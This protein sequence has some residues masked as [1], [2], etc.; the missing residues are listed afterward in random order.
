MKTSMFQK[1]D[2]GRQMTEAWS[3]RSGVCNPGAVIGDRK[4]GKISHNSLMFTLIE[5]LVVIAIIAI[6]AAMLLPALGK[7]KDMAKATSCMNNLKQL[8]TIEQMY[9]L[10]FNEWVASPYTAATDAWYVVYNKA[11]YIDWPKDKNW[12]YCQA[13]PSTF[14]DL[15]STSFIMELYGKDLT[16]VGTSVPA[17]KLTTLARTYTNGSYKV[18]TADLPSFSDTVG[19]DGKQWYT[20]GFEGTGQSAHLRHS[21]AA[22]QSFLDG[23]VRPMRLTDLTSMYI[24]ANYRY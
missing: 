3:R 19:A 15:T 7:A 1:T 14:G 20:F 12:L 22:N 5:L 17:I 16:I 6:L 23:S 4:T 9:L 8:G 21:R 13:D 2:D 18:V 11:G 10:D 24:W